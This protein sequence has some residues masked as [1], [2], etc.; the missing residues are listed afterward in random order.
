[1]KKNYRLKKTISMKQFITEFGEN[2]S[3]HMK[4][5]LLELEVRCVLTRK[6]ESYILDLKHVEH[7]KYACEN[8]SESSGHSMKEY[9][10]GQLVV[11]E[12][13]L[14]LSHKCVENCDVVQSPL[15]ASLYDSLTAEEELLEN[16]LRVKQ[17]DDGNIDFVID[18][19]LSACP[20]VSKEYMDI[21]SRYSA[22]DLS[23]AKKSNK[24]I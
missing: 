14:L 17:I 1:M 3:E 12:G 22:M 23:T 9:A 7:T 20:Q 19:I 15:I 6:E 5:R 4:K 2:F 18:S 16:E 13:R 11:N 24:Y 10:F 8:E 21:I